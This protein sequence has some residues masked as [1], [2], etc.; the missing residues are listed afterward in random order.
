MSENITLK[1]QDSV[2]NKGA[3]DDS[4]Q[5]TG[6][7]LFGAL[8]TNRGDTLNIARVQ[9]DSDQGK[10]SD[11][12][13]LIP[14]F[15]LDEIAKR[16][17]NDD[18]SAKANAAPEAKAN[19]GFMPR[20]NTPGDGGREVYDAKGWPLLPGR[21]ARFEGEKPTGKDDV[22]NV[23]DFTG[24]VRDFYK[25]EYN[26]NSIDDNGMKFV[27]TVD[28]R[29]LPWKAFNN[30][31]WNG[32]QMAYGRPDE[33]SPFK[34]F[35]LL[36]VTAH[37]ITHG[38]TQKEANETYK[39]QSGALN[40]SNSDVFGELIKQY[41]KHQTADQADWLVGDGIWKDGIKGKALRDMLNP[42]TAYD[43]P[44]IGKD[45]QPADMAHYKEMTEDNGG[46]HINSGIPNRAFALFAK[47][48]GGYAWE[49]PGHVWYAARK[50]AGANPTFASFAYETIEAAKAMNKPDVVEKLQKAWDTV[51][52][53]PEKQAVTTPAAKKSA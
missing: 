19:P 39:G 47:A 7:S 21:K 14:P 20:N 32:S 41:S 10:S 45:P 6:R 26:R 24:V 35:M 28:F 9:A 48:V 31:F 1:P 17:H 25:K 27:S 34:T 49:D 18:L 15:M 33:K 22:D 4:S 13:G 36:D 16:A 12:L 43:D 46:V 23:Y 52:V 50:A 8:D 42:G 38:V 44:K 37:E 29:L 51:G 2:E 11:H 40:E 53:K 3:K 5:Q 30:A